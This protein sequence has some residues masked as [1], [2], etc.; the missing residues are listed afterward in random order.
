MS[1]RATDSGP[2][3][4]GR[5]R[6]AGPVAPAVSAGPGPR[7]RWDP[8]VSRATSSFP[9]TA[10]VLVGGLAA[11]AAVVALLVSS[12]APTRY[13]SSTEVAPQLS[14][15]DGSSGTNVFS[16]NI[17]GAKRF[18]DSQ[19]ALMSGRDV[20]TPVEKSSGLSSTEL[21]SRLD[22]K[23]GDS[24]ATV[25]VTATDTDPTR[26][27]EVTAAVIDSY[28][29]VRAQQLR[30]LAKT[31]YDVI[32]S[33]LDEQRL[34]GLVSGELALQL[35]RDLAAI[36]VPLN[37]GPGATLTVVS[38]P[39]LPE[40][41]PKGGVLKALLAFVATAALVGAVL[42][43]R[44]AT[45][46]RVLDARDI[47]ALPGTTVLGLLR[48]HDGDEVAADRAASLLSL[49]VTAPTEVLVLSA[50]PEPLDQT[51][52][53]ALL[54]GLLASG[55]PAQLIT[56]PD[57]TRLEGHLVVRPRGWATQLPELDEPLPASTVLCLVLVQGMTGAEVHAAITSVRQV[58]A[59]PIGLLLLQGRTLP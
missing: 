39:S 47:K 13:T 4:R 23:P 15:L 7:R 54:A 52:S 46:D 56:S 50:L 20:L 38:S 1:A 44:R 5:L 36:L 8:L 55:R 27:Y 37:A 31:R 24:G 35:Q 11:L 21:T 25:V 19:V 22:V 57:E 33:Q 51:A 53:R 6:A 26:A 30:T 42:L 14:L 10:L 41:A 12:A 34:L 3:T 59:L 40:P 16:L 49:P 2:R 48:R 32:Q 43:V 29:T 18:I 9:R 28:R 45:G 58:S 17:D